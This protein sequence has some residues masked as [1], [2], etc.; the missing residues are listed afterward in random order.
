MDWIRRTSM[1][2]RRKRDL[3]ADPLLCDNLSAMLVANDWVADNPPR[4]FHEA[5]QF[6]S[7]YNIAGRS[8]NR[9]GCG[10]QLDQLLRPYY[11][12]D[13]AAGLIDDE[14][15]VYLLAGLLMSDTKYYQLGG[16][17]ADGKDITNRL[18][19]LILEAADR[20]NVAAN[21]TIRVHDGLDRDFFRRGVELLFKH[22]NGWPRFSGDESLVTGFMKNGF[23]A[24]LARQRIAVGCNCMGIP[25]VEY[26]LN[27]CIKVNLARI[28]EVAFDE[29]MAADAE[30]SVE[31]LWQLFEKHLQAAME[32]VFKTTDFQVR[33]NRFNSPE[34]FL[35]L[36]CKG[37]IEKGCDA[38]Y[39]TLD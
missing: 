19:W 16:P 29:L 18:S 35:N 21:L 6:M 22:K 36:F 38:S 31:Q 2:I 11:E 28:F 5:C 39:H 25:G 32:I 4:S 15:A 20:L 1:E 3:E 30:P 14:D 27:D 7:W 17:D 9:E 10:G 12:A 24:E 8:Y 13:E 33:T 34:L 37:P 26:C 23:S